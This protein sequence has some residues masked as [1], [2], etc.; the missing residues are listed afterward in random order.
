MY[1]VY[2]TMTKFRSICKQK[3]FTNVDSR[4]PNTKHEVMDISS[5]CP[6]DEWIVTALKPNGPIL[7]LCIGPSKNINPKADH[8]HINCNKHI[9]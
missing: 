5:R 4:E 3:C 8:A 6:L 2:H 7:V 9:S 1:S